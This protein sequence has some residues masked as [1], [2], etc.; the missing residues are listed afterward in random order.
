MT[1][2]LT[3]Q[4]DD[5][6]ILLSD[7][8]ITQQTVATSD[9]YG[10][11][12]IINCADGRFAFG[13]AGVAQSRN[14]KMNKWIAQ[15]LIK[16]SNGKCQHRD[17]VLNF[18]AIVNESFYKIPE[19]KAWPLRE[20]KLTIVLAGHFWTDRHIY[21][22]TIVFSN[23]EIFNAEGGYAQ[24]ERQLAEFQE[25]VWTQD[26]SSPNPYFEVAAYGN[27]RPFTKSQMDEIGKLVLSGKSREAVVG[28]ALKLLRQMSDTLAARN[29]IGKQIDEIFIPHDPR[30]A[31]IG[32]YHTSKP[33]N[34]V[35]VPPQLNMAG[36]TIRMVPELVLTATPKT[37]DAK[38]WAVQ[39]VSMNR[40]CPCGKGRKYKYCHGDPKNRQEI[41]I[42]M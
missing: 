40:P 14:F 34:K 2:L 37:T 16:A 23:F 9:E 6:S 13:F 39:K 25:F 38:P 19:L 1:A 21:G 28:R 17:L 41:L 30:I 11:S 3:I 26:L 33:T 5:Y 24:T 12:G 4:S 42:R 18:K 22:R 27:W 32:K 10:K 15:T 35:W 36:E 8:R 20:Q 29:N 31:P 7:R